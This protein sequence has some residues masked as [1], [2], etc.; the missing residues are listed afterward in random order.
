[1]DIKMT[2]YAKKCGCGAKLS[3]KKLSEV[4]GKLPKVTNENLLVGTETSDDAG[5]YKLNE[6]LALVQTVD[7][8][9]PIVDDPY[10]FGQIAATNAI[11]DIYAM[12]GDPITA[13]NI[14]CFPEALDLEILGEIL[15]GGAD[16]LNETGAVIVG[17]HSIEDDE[18]K[19]GMAVTGTVNPNKIMKNYGAKEG[20]LLILTK[21]LGVGIISTAMKKDDCDEESKKMVIESM[22]T[23][24]KYASEI[25]RKYDV[26]VCTD[27]TGFGLMG[28]VYEMATASNVTINIKKDMINYIQSAKKYAE[29]GYLPGGI[30]N[31]KA[32]LDGKYIMNEVP[33]YLENIL[34]DPQTSGGL[35]FA[36]NENEVDEILNELNEQDIKSNIVAK[37]IK[38]DKFDIIVD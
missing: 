29:N 38:K 7:F 3:S 12:G 5:V 1:M 22:V 19:Y 13:L 33:E 30:K 37:I 18:P 17:G 21:P 4:L 11:S 8:F 23:L 9:T 6:T 36:C 2:K 32:H 24:N 26:T 35:L 34:F 16:K 15:R 14:V 27:V 25:I 20:Q 10:L 28:H 31:N